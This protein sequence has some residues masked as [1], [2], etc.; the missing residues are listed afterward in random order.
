MTNATG[1]IPIDSKRRTSKRRPW[2]FPPRKNRAVIGEISP[3]L[4]GKAYSKLAILRAYHHELSKPR[5]PKTKT[6]VMRNFLSLLNS[7]LRFPEGFAEP[8][9]VGRSTLYNWQKVYKAGGIAALVPGYKVKS[10][11]GRATFRPLLNYIEMKFPGPPRRNGKYLFL[12]RIKRRWKNPPLECPICLSIFYSMPIPKGT[13]MEKRMKMLNHKIS[14]IGK[15]N[16]DALNAFV[17]D[18]LSGIVFKDHSQ[19]YQF[20]SEKGYGWWPEI[21]IMIRALPR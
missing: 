17:L 11:T 6:G 3:K 21:R 1:P 19:I 2:T 18:C 4:K 14:H 12:P 13:K 5:K 8:G 20:H 10:K 7:G 9:H 16:L 15:P